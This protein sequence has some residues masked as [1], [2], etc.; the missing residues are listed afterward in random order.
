MEELRQTTKNINIANLH[1]D[2]PFYNIVGQIRKA[3]AAFNVK[4]GSIAEQQCRCL[5]ICAAF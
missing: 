1:R 5:L 3:V 4:F 2:F